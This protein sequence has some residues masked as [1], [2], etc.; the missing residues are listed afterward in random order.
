MSNYYLPNK[1]DGHTSTVAR[2]VLSSNNHMS[3]HYD[4]RFFSTRV[5]DS[6]Q[7]ET[8]NI[9]IGISQFLKSFF[10]YYI[11]INCSMNTI[12]KSSDYQKLTPFLS[13]EIESFDSR[14]QRNLGPSFSES[15]VGWQPQIFLQQK[16][17][18]PATHMR[19]PMATLPRVVA[20][21]L[22]CKRIRDMRVQS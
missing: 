13:R 9:L 20:S 3:I 17:K 2:F 12:A 11:K 19:F 22:P 16:V 10:W 21:G 18:L 7:Y 8:D 1:I 6:F 5:V 14:G 4:F 15:T